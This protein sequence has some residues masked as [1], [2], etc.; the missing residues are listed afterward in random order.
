MNDVSQRPKGL[1]SGPIPRRNQLLILAAIA[2]VVLVLWGGVY[3]IGV[4]TAP[5]PA[6]EPPATPGAFRPTPGQWANLTFADVVQRDFAAVIDTDGKVATDDER[7]TQVFSPYSGRVT[8]VI[9]AAG[10]EVRAG[11]PLFAVRAAEFVQAQSD[12]VAALAQ[13]KVAAAAKARQEALF[14]IQGAALKDVQQSEADLANA[15][16]AL[17]AVKNRL[18]ILGAAEETITALQNRPAGSM[19]GETVVRA[20]I[21]GTVVQR[22]VG[23]GQNLA[24][25]VSNGSGAPAF[26]VS[27]LHKVWLVAN[28]R[29][30]DAAGA[31]L[32][33][34]ITATVSAYPG[35]T[36]MGRI[37]FIA[38][39]VDPN[40]RRIAVRAEIDNPAERLRPEMFAELK[41][42]TGPPSAVL[43]VPENAVIYEGQEARVWVVVGGRNLGLRK[44]TVGR[45]AGGFVEVLSGL[46]A[47]DKVVDAGAIFI[48]RAATNG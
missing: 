14:K 44:I 12:L 41:V 47:G 40:T 8:R 10:Q 24:S 22:S 20:P 42:T 17:E 9:A 5:K 39:S 16:A 34:P 28:V 6:P 31:H 38:P 4:M 33:A 45:T 29:E 18:R 46:N 36:F 15:Q 21:T 19:E 2:I 43:S 7:T 1:P 26:T 30:E 11:Q 35:Q 13:L 3:L 25:L 32:G 27:D 23:V 48:D 37:N